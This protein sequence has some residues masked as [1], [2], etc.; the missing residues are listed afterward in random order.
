MRSLIFLLFMATLSTSGT[1]DTIYVPQDYPTI[2][3]AIDAANDL[4][5]V[6]VSPG[7]YD[8]CIDLRGKAVTVRSVEGPEVTYIQY[9]GTLFPV[10]RIWDGP[11]YP[12][13]KL[14]GFTMSDYQLEDDYGLISIIGA[15]G[16]IENNIIR[17]CTCASG[18]EVHLIYCDNSASLIE[19]NVISDNHLSDYASSGIFCVFGQCT[20]KGNDIRDNSFPKY[21]ACVNCIQTTA[22]VENNILKSNSLIGIRCQETLLSMHENQVLDTHGGSEGGGGIYMCDSSHG[23]IGKNII[24]GGVNAPGVICTEYSSP[25]LMNNMI[26]GN[27]GGVGFGGGVRC[28][29]FSSPPLGFNTIF[30]NTAFRGGGVSSDQYSW[31]LIINSII[32]GNSAC[33]GSQISVGSDSEP[34]AMTISFSDVEGGES[35]V[36]LAPGSLLDWGQGMIDD[37]PLFVDP[38]GYDFHLQYMSPCRD[39]GELDTWTLD[40]EGDTRVPGYADMGADE[41]ANRLYYTGNPSPGGNMELKIIGLPDEVIRLW[42]GSDILES[43]VY[44][45]KY[46][47]W[48][49]EAPILLSIILGAIPSPS[50]VYILPVDIPVGYT[51]WDIPLQA[52]IG[53]EFSNLCV[54]EME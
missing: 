40:Y 26:Y 14:I 46:G 27:D 39:T 36:H 25:G 30:G 4:D 8:E 42:V 54:V 2:Q 11:Y 23:R 53:M 3:E 15:G 29:D 34:S 28:V 17:N 10:V 7:T 1:A 38:E 31:P 37:D 32:W 44:Y 5:E 43:S 45:P 49:L 18:D 51:P 50:G 6:L 22:F 9:S 33:E 48:Y 13:A 12:H 16:S 35:M 24:A 20:I 41:F 47:T 21:G 19:N 52:G